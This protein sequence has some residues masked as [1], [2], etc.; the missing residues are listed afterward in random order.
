MSKK[1]PYDLY[2]LI[3]SQETMHLMVKYSFKKQIVQ[4]P[5]SIVVDSDIDFDL[6]QKAF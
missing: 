5:C 4:I 1:I 3:P 6:M 2:D